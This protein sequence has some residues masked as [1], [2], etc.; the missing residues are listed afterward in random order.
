MAESVTS[1]N[2]TFTATPIDGVIVVEARQFPDN[3]GVFAEAYKRCDFEAGGITDDFVQEN[4]SQSKH[5]VLRGLHY[6]KN[7]PQSKLVRVL[8]GEA[9]DVAVDLR[10]ESPTFGKWYG[11]VLSGE[12][13]RQLYIPHGCA[14]GILV[15]SDEAVFCYRADDVYHPEDGAAIA[16]DDPDIG[17]E[18][19]IAVGEVVLSQKDATNP[20]FKE[21]FR[22]VCSAYLVEER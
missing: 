19:P 21:S 1:G 22:S 17:V 9:F 7:H 16:W 15:L 20:G 5:G 3:R 4:Q 12:N 11:E 2:F 10:P 18:W 8:S 6:Q 13:G 14:H